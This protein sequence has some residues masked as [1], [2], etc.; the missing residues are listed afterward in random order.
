MIKQVP[1]LLI[2]VG[3]VVLK[4]GIILVMVYGLS[5][6]SGIAIFFGIAMLVAGV[7]LKRKIKRLNAKNKKDH[8]DY[9]ISK[10]M[11]DEDKLKDDEKN[12]SYS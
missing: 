6:Y 10:L 9:T 7:D 3:I 12:N 4:L 8:H 5:F 1:I 11:E 2:I